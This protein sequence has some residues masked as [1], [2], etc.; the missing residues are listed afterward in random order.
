[1]PQKSGVIWIKNFDYEIPSC[2]VY[3]YVDCVLWC[4]VTLKN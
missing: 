4:Y 3:I 1:M 2:C